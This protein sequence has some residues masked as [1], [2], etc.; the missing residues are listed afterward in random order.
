MAS[1]SHLDLIR[2]PYGAYGVKYI[3]LVSLV[4]LVSLALAG[5]VCMTHMARDT[6]STHLTQHIGRHG[7][8]ILKEIGRHGEESV[9]F[10]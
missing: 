8:V 4:S 10:L 6:G 3:D 7:D 5:S 2:A 1:Q 9:L